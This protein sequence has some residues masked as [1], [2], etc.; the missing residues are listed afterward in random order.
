MEEL[1][2]TSLNFME[3]LIIDSRLT[4]HGVLGRPTLKDLGAI[5]FIYHLCMKFLTEQG[6]T[7]VK[8]DQRGARKCYLNLIRKAKPKDANVINCI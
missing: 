4:Y 2:Q 8:D 6:I 3:F 1:S 7:M 5:T